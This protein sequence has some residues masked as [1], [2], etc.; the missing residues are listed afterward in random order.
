MGIDIGLPNQQCLPH[1]WHVRSFCQISLALFLGSL[2]LALVYVS[3]ILPQ[4]SNVERNTNMKSS[5]Y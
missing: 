3:V 4:Y 1:M 5:V 2:S